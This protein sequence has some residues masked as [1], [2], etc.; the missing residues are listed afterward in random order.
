MFLRCRV[1]Q[2]AFPFFEELNEQL[3]A[4]KFSNM[5]VQL[6]RSSKGLL[7]M[8]DGKPIQISKD[9]PLSTFRRMQ[10]T[11]CL[12]VAFNRVAN[13]TEPILLFAEPE[14]TLPSTLHDEL[15]DFVIN[16]SKTCQCLYSFSDIDI[17]PTI[18]DCKR[19][20]ATELNLT[21]VP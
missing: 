15:A 14:R 9:E 21:E 1:T 17:F 6:D 11:A 3:T 7:P 20:S 2:G 4:S 12:A 5:T 18:T 19:Y 13:K 16:I 8:I 10:A